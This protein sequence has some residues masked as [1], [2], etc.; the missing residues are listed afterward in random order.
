MKDD[1]WDQVITHQSRSR[2]SPDARRRQ[3]DDE[4]GRFGRIVNITSVVGATG[5][6]GQMN[7]C[8]AKAGLTA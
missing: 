7:Y 4:G 5:N 8:A 2:F 1:E 6:P 3:A